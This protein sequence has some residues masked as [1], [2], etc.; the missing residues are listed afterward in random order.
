MARRTA[1]KFGMMTHFD[2]LKL[3]DVVMAATWQ[4]TATAHTNFGSQ[5]A[6]TAGFV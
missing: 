6:I 4:K 2:P 3:G 1:I 5:F